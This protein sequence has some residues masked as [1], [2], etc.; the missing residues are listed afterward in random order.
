MELARTC[1]CRAIGTATDTA[2]RRTKYVFVHWVG[3]E[4]P[5]VRRGQWNAGRFKMEE[6][7]RMRLFLDESQHG[8]FEVRGLEM[9]RAIGTHATH[10]T[11]SVPR[12]GCI[13][14]KLP[15]HGAEAR[16]LGGCAVC[17]RS[18][19]TEDLY[20]LDLFTKPTRGDDEMQRPECAATEERGH[21]DAEKGPVP[22]PPPPF[23][24]ST[25]STAGTD[26]AAEAR[27]A[28]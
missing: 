24:A 11:H 27:H 5:P 14:H 6:E 26:A 20:E 16:C 12:S 15:L 25:L 17:A 7:I 10:Q 23:P 28:V 18:F 1:Y 13:S 3:P 2:T 22:R 8:P 19:W 9:R 21:A 4:A